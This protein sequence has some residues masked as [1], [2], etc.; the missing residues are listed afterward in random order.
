M[1]KGGH[2]VVD[3]AGGHPVH[4]G[5]HDHR[6]QGPV[7]APAWLQ[8]GGEERAGPQLGDA[9]VDVAGL[10]GHEASAPTVAVGG[11]GLGSLIAACADGLVSLGFDQGLQHQAHGLSQHV[12]VPAGAQGVEQVGQGRLVEGHRFG[13]LRDSGLEHVEDHAMAPFAGGP[14]PNPDHQSPVEALNEVAW[15]QECGRFG[16]L[17]PFPPAPEWASNPTTLGDTYQGPARRLKP[18]LTEM[19]PVRF[20]EDMLAEMQRRAEA[21]DRSVSAW[22]RRAVERE[23]RRTAS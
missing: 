1:P 4:V 23:L 17:R 10:G 9:Q 2:Q 19:V 5:L 22:I 3:L 7:Y 11:A 20:P 14:S 21:D 12:E 15:Y 18:R 16:R 6:P 8:Q 13:L